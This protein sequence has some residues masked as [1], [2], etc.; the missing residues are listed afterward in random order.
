MCERAGRRTLRV[1]SLLGVAALTLLVGIAAGND[2]VDAQSSRS[3]FGRLDPVRVLGPGTVRISGWA[4]DPDTR[5]GIPVLVAANGRLAGGWATL[6]RADLPRRDR[7]HGY[8]FTIGGL[9]PGLVQVCAGAVNVGPGDPGRLV[10]CQTVNT[11]GDTSPIGSIDGLTPTGSDTVRVDGWALDPDTPFPTPVDVLV[12]GAVATR[13]VAAQERPDLARAFPPLGPWHGLSA[14]VRVPEGRHQICLRPQNLAAGATRLA[15]CATYDTPDVWPR[16]AV[17]SVSVVGGEVVVTG[18]T[19]ERDQ[20]TAPPVAVSFDDPGPGDPAVVSAMVTGTRAD[21][22]ASF[23]ASWRPERAGAHQVCVAAANRGWG[24]D[25]LLGCAALDVA[26]RRPA[27]GITALSAGATSVTVGGTAT[28]PDGGPVP[29][30]VTTDRGASVATTTAGPGW[31][32]TLSGLVAGSHRICV[33][34]TDVAGAAGIDGPATW[35]GGALVGPLRVGH[36]GTIEGEAAVGPPAGSAL[37]DVDRDGGVSVR[38]RDGSVLWLFGD[39]TARD[40][41]GG[42]RYFVSGTAAW[43][44]ATDPGS[45]R[46][47][48]LDGR[49]VVAAAPGA[50]TPACDAQRPNAALW[51]M[52]AVAVPDGPRDRVIAWFAEMCLGPQPSFAARGTAVATW[53]YDPAAP[54][55]AQPVS[56][57]VLRHQLWTEPS[58]GEAAVLDDDGRI[59]TYTCDGPDQGGWFDQYGPCTVARV[60][61]DDAADP[62]A[63]RYW[64]GASWSADP[65]D[66][67][68]LSMPAPGAGGI[69]RHPPAAFTVAFD[70]A[71][72][73]WV[74]AY[75]SWPGF[76]EVG[77]VRFA[78]DPLGPWSEPLRIDLPDCPITVAGELRSCYALTLQPWR[79]AAGRLGLGFYRMWL[80]ADVRRGGYRSA[81]L[82]LTLGS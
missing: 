70:D 15:A 36:A 49:P 19:V 29:I 47:A 40:T 55:D 14:E 8:A 69:G 53:T 38:L 7:R 18:W 1:A 44:P 54:P 25:R 78:T 71:L 59:L 13:A 4:V 50:G 75:T 12:D 10:G 33:E 68:P 41:S 22:A 73:R 20:P 82:P 9:P 74:M 76:T 45:T 48:V 63:Y 43:A 21:G 11:G 77:W 67:A 5:R 66:A 51:P 26:D 65:A 24:A 80:P 37:A 17:E 42:L 35:C 79:S 23:R 32:A 72:G 16:G 52:S 30:R 27:G 57:T 31:T 81:A 56:F 6:A 28:D 61:P 46:D 58:Y 2:P 62:S 60:D 39:S 64:D 3:P 34:A